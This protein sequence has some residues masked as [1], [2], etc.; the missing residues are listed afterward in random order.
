M[1]DNLRRLRARAGLT[2]REVAR[3]AMV[4]R[5]NLSAIESGRR[6]LTVGTLLRLG[7]ALGADPADLLRPHPPEGREPGRFR[8]DAIARAVISG[9]RGLPPGD[10]SLADALAA[11][12]RPA[13]EAAGASGARRASP[14]ALTRARLEWPERVIELL[15][16]RVLKLLASGPAGEVP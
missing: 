1:A 11:S 15:E 16:R 6:D 4:T 12:C 5:P 7:R 10:R 14:R 3:R 2:Q 8:A 13:L 9:S